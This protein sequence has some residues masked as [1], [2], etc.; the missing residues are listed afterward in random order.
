MSVLS[1]DLLCP[2]AQVFDRMD[3]SQQG[4]LLTARSP[5]VAET[6]ARFRGK[7]LTLMTPNQFLGIVPKSPGR[8]K[9]HNGDR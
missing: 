5:D 9:G 7:G 4:V 2:I 8:D 6:I 3:A 1:F